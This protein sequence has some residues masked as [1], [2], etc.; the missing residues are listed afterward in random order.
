MGPGPV[1]AHLDHA[2]GFADAIAEAPAGLL[3]DLGSGAGVP[4]LALAVSRPE[5]EWLFLDGNHRSADFLR[6]A[7]G[8]LGLKGRVTVIQGRAEELGHDSRLRG[9]VQ[10][11]VA[12]SFGPPAVTAECA[13][14][15][16]GQG[17]R[18]VV[19]DT[20]EWDPRRWPTNG[21]LT[22]GQRLVRQVKSVS[23]HHFTVI[24]QF[25]PVSERFARRTG[26]P[27]RRPLF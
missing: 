18:L 8:E 26:V 6:E 20:P 10:T 2:R 4:G 19:S 15:F 22:L 23:G 9:K 5:T 12:R 24:E 27:A 16:L 7:T 21:L 3:L 14:G 25:E 13:A 1:E 17:G 11:V